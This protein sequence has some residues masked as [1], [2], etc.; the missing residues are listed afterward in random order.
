MSDAA[1]NASQ[2]FFDARGLL[3]KTIDPLGNVSSATYDSNDNLLERYGTH[4]SYEHVHLRFARQYAEFEERRGP[5]HH[6]HLRFAST[7]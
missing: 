2:Y 5:N 3:V 7:V 1:G 6:V 4:E